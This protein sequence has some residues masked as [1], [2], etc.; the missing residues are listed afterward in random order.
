MLVD[1]VRNIISSGAILMISISVSFAG[2]NMKGERVG[3]EFDFAVI[4]PAAEAGANSFGVRD[5][6]VWVSNGDAL[7]DDDATDFS[8]AEAKLDSNSVKFAKGLSDIFCVDKH[9]KQNQYYLDNFSAVCPDGKSK[10]HGNLDELSDD[11]ARDYLALSANLKEF[12]VR[13]GI[14]LARLAVSAQS[15]SLVRGVM[16]VVVKFYNGGRESIGFIHPDIWPSSS[17]MVVGVKGDDENAW[18]VKPRL[19]RGDSGSKKAE[20]MIRLLPGETFQYS[21]DG[22]PDRK[23]LVGSYGVSA[24]VV[25]DLTIGNGSTRQRVGFHSDYKNPN[26]VTID[27]D[28][29]STPQE[30]EQW[31]A[32]HR[33]SMSLQPV[34]PGE[35]FVE[36][37]LYRAVRLIS[38]ASYRS[39]QVKPFNGRWIERIEPDS[40]AGNYTYRLSSLITRRAG[41]Q[42]P[43]IQGD[44][45]KTEWEWVGA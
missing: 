2:E 17:L 24:W 37:G 4:P 33:A 11:F 25:M 22:V 32:Q 14:D 3:G 20:E 38:G 44:P 34:K 45:G 8:I 41:Q 36:D 21:F 28:Y 7:F 27:H 30:R 10:V 16:T 26:H 39:L 29:P 5:G 19:E 12:C 43:Q 40:W 13:N 23:I 18:R 35:T 42:M 9:P 6:K 15:V 1:T 31:E